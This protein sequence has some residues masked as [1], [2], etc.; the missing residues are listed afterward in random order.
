MALPN[1]I[2]NSTMASRFNRMAGISHNQSTYS[3]LT[4][5]KHLRD[6]FV[7]NYLKSKNHSDVTLGSSNEFLH[8][9][10]HQFGHGFGIGVLEF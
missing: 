7:K 5:I 9:S 1:G 8:S 6:Y 2:I 4:N 10:H 3:K